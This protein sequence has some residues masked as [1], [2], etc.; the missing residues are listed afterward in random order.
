MLRVE[1]IDGLAEGDEVVVTGGDGL[2]DGTRV[3]ATVKPP[4]DGVKS[5]KGGQSGL[6]L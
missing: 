2:A 6:T 1:I 5:P 3:S 4:A